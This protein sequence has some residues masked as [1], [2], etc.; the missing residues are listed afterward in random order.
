[1]KATALSI[2]MC[3]ALLLTLG[4]GKKEAEEGAPAGPVAQAPAATPIDPATAAT[5]VGTVKL[6]GSVPKPRTINM[7]A[8]PACAKEH[9]GKPVGSQEIVVG[10][11]GALA[12]VIVYV[13]E[14]LGNRAFDTPRQEVVIDQRGCLYTPRVVTVQTNQTLQVKNSDATTHNIHPVPLVNREWNKSQPAGAPAISETFARE[15][16]AIPVKCNVHPWM[17]SYV[18]VFAHPYHRV[19]GADGAFE[20][21]NLPPGEYLIEAWHE[22]L[23]TA[24]AKVT[25]GAKETKT[26]AFTFTAAAGD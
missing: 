15:E 17:K 2:M 4:C 5:L 11:G 12:N 18:G 25:L 14:G 7:A 1:M 6:E 23:G 8:E 21:T 13:K 22:K 16:V 9:A 24:Q 19:T 26:V 3:C 20:L 10:S